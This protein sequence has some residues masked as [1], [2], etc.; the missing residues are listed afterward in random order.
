MVWPILI[1]CHNHGHKA[2]TR[3]GATSARNHSR[4]ITLPFGASC[5][6]RE[7]MSTREDSK[8]RVGLYP[9]GS[10]AL[11][12]SASVTK[13]FLQFVPVQARGIFGSVPVLPSCVYLAACA[14]VLIPS[15]LRTQFSLHSRTISLTTARSLSRSLSTSTC[16]SQCT[17]TFTHASFY[18]F[19]VVGQELSRTLTSLPLG[20]ADMQHRPHRNP[21][22]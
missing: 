16:F 6:C 17:F 4:A 7:K 12:L 8:E 19:G 3:P 1:K 5:N 20:T 21:S 15:Q 11:R 18:C 9:R 10:A 14:R 2:A 22:L 13:C